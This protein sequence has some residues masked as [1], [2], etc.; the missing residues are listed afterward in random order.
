MSARYWSTIVFAILHVSIVAAAEDR[1]LRTP[2]QIAAVRE[3]AL[4]DV[5]FSASYSQVKTSFPSAK[6]APRS[7]RSADALVLEASLD[8][9]GKAYF[10]F[11]SKGERI[12]RFKMLVKGDADAGLKK[13][14]KKFGQPT[15]VQE[16]KMDDE[17]LSVYIWRYEDDIE[18]EVHLSI[19]NKL[20]DELLI[21]T[22]VD[23]SIKL[24]PSAR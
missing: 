3:F 8:E 14:L 9:G 12:H 21:L 19:R 10:F 6:N 18:R 5:S 24:E 7:S 1:V 2:E 16:N 15:S 17:K 4:G 20:G 13:V 22:V 11:T 23:T